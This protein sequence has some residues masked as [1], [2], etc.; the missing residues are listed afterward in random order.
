MM[1]TNRL[2]R[3]DSM[4]LMNV[5]S[6]AAAVVIATSQVAVA[7]TLDDVKARGLPQMTLVFGRVSTFLSAALLLL[8]Y[9]ATQKKYLSPR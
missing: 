4:K 7:A 3:S 9:W 2:F 1:K 8:R 6:T 5:A